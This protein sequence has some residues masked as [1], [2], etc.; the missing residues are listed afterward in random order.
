[1]LMDLRFVYMTA[2]DKEEARSIGKVLVTEKLAACVNIFDGM[3]SLY[4]WNEQLKDDTE[5]VLIAKTTEERVAK[6][7]ERVKA[8]HSYDCPCIVVLPLVGGNEEFLEWVRK[9]T[10]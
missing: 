9:A 6:L 7:I 2:K 5:A 1:M 3:N 8:L 10:S 4:F